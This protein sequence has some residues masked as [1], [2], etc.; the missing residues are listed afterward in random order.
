MTGNSWVL[1]TEIHQGKILKIVTLEKISFYDL[2]IGLASK[3]PKITGYQT[4]AYFEVILC[5]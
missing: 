3:D 2:M 1:T 4:L 5:L